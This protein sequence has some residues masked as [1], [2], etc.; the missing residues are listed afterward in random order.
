[1]RIKKFNS[2]INE[3]LV[4]GDKGRERYIDLRGPSGNAYAI[5][6]MAKDLTNQLKDVNEEIY[7]WE[8]IEKEMTESDYTNLVNTFEKYFGDYVTIYNADV[9]DE[10]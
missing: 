7:N 4:S 3:A 8:R 2:F 6:G 10:Q 5:L 9:L 1:M